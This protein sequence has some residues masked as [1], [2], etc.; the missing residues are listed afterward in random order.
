MQ[1]RAPVAGSYRTEPRG[2][3]Q[4]GGASARA[5]TGLGTAGTTLEWPSGSRGRWAR[6]LPCHRLSDGAGLWSPP[7][8][9]GG[10]PPQ[11][12]RYGPSHPRRS[13]HSLRPHSRGGRVS[14]DPTVR[15][16]WLPTPLRP[17]GLGEVSRPGY[18][19]TAAGR[20]DSPG[21]FVGGLGRPPAV[22][23]VAGGGTGAAL[24]VYEPPE[25]FPGWN[26]DRYIVCE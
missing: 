9:V 13:I 1:A 14:R 4:A 3:T 6:R 20:R 19:R 23:A 25:G 21:L 11:S 8:G 10:R 2:P 26:F 24:W 17:L 18:F 12:N 7:T 16:A 22:P 15:L 5:L